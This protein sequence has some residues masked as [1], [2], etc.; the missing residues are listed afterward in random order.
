MRV[1]EQE[2]R[3][4]KEEA[5]RREA[6][7][8]EMLLRLGR[9]MAPQRQ[10]P[11]PS[12]DS[13]VDPKDPTRKL[14]INVRE[15]RGGTLG[16]AGVIG[17]AGESDTQKRSE[18]TKAKRP[19]SASSEIGP[20]IEQAELL[21]TG[22]AVDP[23]SGVVRPVD[24]PTGSTVGNLVD[25]AGRAVGL[26][27]KGS[28]T[29]QRLKAVGGAL[30]SKMPRMEGPQSDYDVK[31]YREMAGQIGD[32]NIPVSERITALETVRT[33]WEKYEN[34]NPGTFSD[35]RAATPADEPPP[36]AVRRKR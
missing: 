30:A 2:R 8:R 35:R 27:P 29:S 15:Y 12:M 19:F 25:I 21:L 1:Q 10:E 11:A 31:L 20:I 28:A 23:A 33:L 18:N 24:V 6:S 32:P 16:D 9:A 17:V 22:R 4:T 5:D 13:I 36:G 7:M 26:S 34:Q 3:I 14:R